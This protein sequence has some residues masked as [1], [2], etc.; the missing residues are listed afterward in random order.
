MHYVLHRV[1]QTESR[2]AL[3]E[4]HLGRASYNTKPRAT[5]F[6]ANRKLNYHWC[7]PQRGFR[8]SGCFLQGIAKRGN[9]PL[10][11]KSYP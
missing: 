9:W 11:S 7:H 6:T 5:L 8:L 1:V 2:S 10:W 4:N 3:R